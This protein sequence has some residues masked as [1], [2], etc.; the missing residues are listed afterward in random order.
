MSNF[1]NH[2]QEALANQFYKLTEGQYNFIA[3]TPFDERRIKIGYEDM[4][5]KY[6][7]ILRPYEKSEH[8]KKALELMDKCDVVIFGAGDEKYFNARIKTGKLT[9]RCL[10]R[11]LKRGTYTRFIPIFRKRI[12]NRYV[13]WR[14]GN[15]N[16]LCASA[17]TASDLNLCGFPV[18]K[19][20][21]FGYFPAIKRY[22]D[23]ERIID[24]K[25]KKSILWCG[26]FMKLKHPEAAIQVAE[27]LKRDGYDFKLDIIGTGELKGVLE[28]MIEEKHLTKYINMIGAVSQSEVS[29]Y[30]EKASV[31]M[32]NSNFKEGWGVVLSE[33]MNAGCACVVSH[34]IGSAPYLIKDGENGFIYKNLDIDDLYK[35]VKQLLDDENKCR[36]FAKNAYYTI[37]N[38]WNPENAASQFIDLTNSIFE[39][40]PKVN[41][42]GVCSRAQILRNNWYK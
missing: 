26:R 21:K 34:A 36:L 37:L 32:F 23:I 40:N 31:F 1:M 16:I 28:T 19:C 6:D 18:D 22:D 30:M 2:H 38:E 15:F 10:E 24:N 17:Y 35:K 14:N 11:P 25:E 8:D 27:R 5:K 7:Y 41:E 12:Y 33:A 39:G 9:F 42:D 3:C 4:N 20:Y 13:K 29:T